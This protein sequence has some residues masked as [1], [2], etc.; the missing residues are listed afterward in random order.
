M[1]E[2]ATEDGAAP[3][4]HCCVR[5]L[6][7]A[8]LGECRRLPRVMDRDSGATGEMVPVLASLWVELEAD[9]GWLEGFAREELEL[10]YGSNYGS[11]E[12]AG[13]KQRSKMRSLLI[14]LI[15]RVE[16]GSNQAIVDLVCDQLNCWVFWLRSW[17]C[18]GVRVRL[19][20][21]RWFRL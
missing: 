13:A 15:D 9:D 11:I 4:V 5:R 16:D 12:A 21:L 17:F 1:L 14:G 18:T 6:E 3:A 2:E 8:R 19:T 10:S 20:S 7:G